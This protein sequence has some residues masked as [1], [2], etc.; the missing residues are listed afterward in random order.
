MALVGRVVTPFLA[1]VG[2]PMDEESETTDS[3]EDDDEDEEGD[4]S[5]AG[6]SSG[7]EAGVP[8]T[9]QA[10]LAIQDLPMLVYKY[11]EEH[12]DQLSEAAVPVVTMYDQVCQFLRASG[13]SQVMA[14]QRLTSLL[15]RDWKVKMTTVDAGN[16]LTPAYMF[17]NL[18]VA[19][20][21]EIAKK[22]KED[23]GDDLM[24][25]RAF[26][27]TRDVKDFVLLK[28]LNGWAAVHG[29]SKAK[30]HDRLTKMGAIK[31]DS[32]CVRG[33]KHGRGF[34]KLVMVCED[35]GEV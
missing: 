29:L 10:D 21:P 20:A 27:V 23:A 5:T 13:A 6:E 25:R 12:R 32:C 22:A 18:R 8:Q 11:I 9:T 26:K 3:S 30:L 19:T 1:V 16:G 15:V 24:M 34:M 14:S 31:S 35:G 7:L 17:E 4:E 2:T 33:V 28:D